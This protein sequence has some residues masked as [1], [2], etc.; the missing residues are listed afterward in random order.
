MPMKN[1]V[2]LLCG[3]RLRSVVAS[4]NGGRCVNLYFN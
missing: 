4:L 2:L 3:A 1:S